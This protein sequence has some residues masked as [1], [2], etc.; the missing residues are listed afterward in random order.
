M[1]NCRHTRVALIEKREIIPFLIESTEIGWIATYNLQGV[2]R[3]ESETLF[4]CTGC[5]VY[6]TKESHPLLYQA[7]CEAVEKETGGK[8]V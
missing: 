5:G 2:E 8:C 3:V 6:F 7:L 4:M 1:K